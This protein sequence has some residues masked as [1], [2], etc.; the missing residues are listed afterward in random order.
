VVPSGPVVDPEWALFHLSRSLWDPVDPARVGSLDPALRYRVNGEVYRFASERTLRRFVEAP[1]LWCGLLRD[2]V[3]G[4]RFWPLT[5][6]PEAYWLGG[7][8]LFENDSTWAAFVADP[9]RY[10]VVRGW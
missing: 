1:A 6:S 5:R 4:N 7:T 2:P 9:F 8:Y 3:S 10:E